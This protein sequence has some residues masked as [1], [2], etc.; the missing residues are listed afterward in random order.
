VN[1]LSSLG[2]L[3][4]RVVCSTLENPLESRLAAR[5]IY[6]DRLF[7]ET[8]IRHVKRWGM[9]MQLDLHDKV[10]RMLYFVGCSE[11]R[12]M[13]LVKSLLRPDWIVLDIGA[14]IGVYTLFMAHLLDPKLGRVYAFEPNPDTFPL[15]KHHVHT[16][17]L[18]HVFPVNVALGSLVADAE[19]FIAPSNNSSMSSMHRRLEGSRCATVK[20]STLERFCCDT[21]IQRID[22]IKMDAEGAEPEIMEGGRTILGSLRPQMLLEVNGPA[23]S[24]NG[25]CPRDLLLLLRD[26][27]YA[28]F[29][30]DRPS[31]ELHPDDLQPLDFVN[32]Y[33][34]PRS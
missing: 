19:F 30:I 32:V 10:P 25:R 11:P 23:L 16:N 14:H 31:S 34:R 22:F 28:V 8:R 27:N 7:P 26:L 9:S 2:E 5:W 15:L 33:C 17:N 18:T 21:G 24:R 6:G 4:L 20:V 3:Y 1:L 13:E 29:P 12:E